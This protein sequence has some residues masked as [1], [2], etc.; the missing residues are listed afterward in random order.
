MTEIHAFDPDGT[1]SPGAQTALDAAVDGFATEGYVDDASAALRGD[2]PRLVVSSSRPTPNRGALWVNP[3][4]GVTAIGVDDGPGPVTN[5]A[6]NPR[7]AGGAGPVAR[8]EPIS[9][10]V[11]SQ[12][13]RYES[14]DTGVPGQSW[15]ERK[16]ALVDAIISSGVDII[17][18]QEN[19][20]AG[21]S[22]SQV[23][24]LADLLGGNWRVLDGSANNGILYREDVFQP[25]TPQNTVEINRSHLQAGTQRSM[26]YATFAHRESERR[27]I[28]AVTHFQVDSSST[29]DNPGRTESAH[30]VGKLL[31]GMRAASGDRPVVV[32]TGDFNQ[33]TTTDNSPYGILPTYG[34]TNT[35]DAASSVINDGLNSYNDFDPDM[36]GRANGAWVDAIFTSDDVDV[37]EAGLYVKFESGSGL[38]LATPLPSDHN[39]VIAN[40]AVAAMPGVR[41]QGSNGTATTGGGALAYQSYAWSLDGGA[42]ACVDPVQSSS[43]ATCVYPAGQSG[44]SARVGWRA[45]ETWTVAATIR[46]GAAQGGTLDANARTI[47][48]GY[49]N[50][51]GT[52][53]SYATSTP[54]PN[55]AGETRLSVTFTIPEDADNVFIRLMNGSRDTKTYWDGLVI[56]RGDSDPGPRSGDTLGWAW[57]GAPDASTSTYAGPSWVPL[58]R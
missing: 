54:A 7:F 19:G 48:I 11:G 2:T 15:D 56:V 26:T 1:P 23:R 12:N 38:P 39:M 45:G 14:L 50:G 52:V 17:G 32:L 27:V 4:S 34:L 18:C 25:L 49:T 53:W 51:S 35:R 3:S 40:V 21:N 47:N 42:S 44:A 9:F 41:M 20:D 30:I 46:L 5:Y 8:S 58:G 29:G 36:S 13:L 6:T 31:E 37:G 22:R 10:R 55:E 16:P 24:Q 33:S 43:S 28:F 57:D